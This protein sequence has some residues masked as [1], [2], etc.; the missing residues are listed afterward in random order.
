LNTTKSRLY[1]KCF[2]GYNLVIFDLLLINLPDKFGAI[3]ISMSSEGEVDVLSP[4][5]DS[6]MD[7]KWGLYPIL[8]TLAVEEGA[9]PGASLVVDQ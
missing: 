6:V 4:E 5:L 8:E 7:Y 1:I 2:L 3:T 9:N